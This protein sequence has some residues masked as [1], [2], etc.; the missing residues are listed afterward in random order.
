MLS[1]PSRGTGT[2][3]PPGMSPDPP[4][5]GARRAGSGLIQPQPQAGVPGGHRGGAQGRARAAGGGR[6]PGSGT[7]RHGR[8]PEGESPVLGAGLGR[9]YRG[10][11]GEG[12][13]G[14]KGRGIGGFWGARGVC[15]G[16]G[17]AAA[18]PQGWGI[19]NRDGTGGGDGDGGV[20][21]GGSEG[22][23]VSI[24]CPHPSPAREAA[25]L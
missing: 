16:E 14:G 7:R 18:N 17:R 15:G 5:W 22:L 2:P 23:P 12:T 6:T 9:G 20:G 21:P 19:G 24:R 25:S 4:P 3:V 8:G 1:T 11:R 13:G 10:Y